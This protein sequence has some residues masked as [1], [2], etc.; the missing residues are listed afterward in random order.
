MTATP[1]AAETLSRMHAAFLSHPAVKG[2]S[3]P[4][5]DAFIASSAHAEDCRLL[6][7]LAQ[8]GGTPD[9]GGINEEEEDKQSRGCSCAAEMERKSLLDTLC[10]KHLLDVRVSY[11]FHPENKVD[12]FPA[13]LL[14]CLEN[15][16]KKT[17]N[18]AKA[19]FISAYRNVLRGW[20]LTFV[21]HAQARPRRPK[22]EAKG[23]PLTPPSSRQ[24]SY[25]SSPA[26]CREQPE[27]WQYEWAMRDYVFGYTH[28]AASGFASGFAAGL[29]FG[30]S[31]Y[32]R[33]PHG[34]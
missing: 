17:K 24:S 7:V 13:A 11:D 26:Y 4:G 21:C 20:Q 5:Y 27:L 15:Q 30:N 33:D 6:V 29:A 31:D 16:D 2:D 32:L 22:K 34:Y 25:L 23:K 28:M 19:R 1:I 9:S 14:K 8:G 10:L 3:L 18:N 12:I